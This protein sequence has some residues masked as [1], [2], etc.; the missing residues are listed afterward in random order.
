MRALLCKLLIPVIGLPSS[1]GQYVHAAP[2]VR[3]VWAVRQSFAVDCVVT[4]EF[5]KRPIITR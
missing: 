4:N 5:L 2:A 3:A 1:N